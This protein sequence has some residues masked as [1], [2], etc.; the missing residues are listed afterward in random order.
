MTHWKYGYS[1]SCKQTKITNEWKKWN[2]KNYSRRARGK[3]VV[4]SFYLSAAIITIMDANHEEEEDDN[5][6]NNNYNAKHEESPNKK[7]GKKGKE[8][9]KKEKRKYYIFLVKS[10]THKHADNAGYTQNTHKHAGITQCTQNTA[11]TC[12]HCAQNLQWLSHILFLMIDCSSE[13]KEK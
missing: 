13:S 12:I 8:K 11:W 3:F 4:A 6:N 7:R 5:N 1:C 10:I 2:F 9:K